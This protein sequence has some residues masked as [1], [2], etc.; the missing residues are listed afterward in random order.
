M[1][2]KYPDAMLRARCISA[3]ARLAFPDIIGGMYTPEE[4]GAPVNVTPMGAVELDQ[5]A[6]PAPMPAGAD[7]PPTPAFQTVSQRTMSRLHAR[8]KEFGFQ[9]DDIHDLALWEFGVASKN[10][11]SEEQAAFLADNIHERGGL[12]SAVI[13][14]AAAAGL[15]REQVRRAAKAEM[16]AYVS[17]TRLS[18][19]RAYIEGL[20]PRTDTD[21]TAAALASL[22]FAAQARGLTDSDLLNMAG[23]RY[24]AETLEELTEDSAADLQQFVCENYDEKPGGAA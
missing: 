9:P 10:E 7:K 2:Q 4:I 1:W 17:N 6:L 5:T 19:L 13:E 21:P 23:E 12:V 11:M 8:G 22:F 14:A 16:L 20:G 15:T 3:A 24:G 18:E